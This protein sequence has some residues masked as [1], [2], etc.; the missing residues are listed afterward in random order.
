[1]PYIFQPKQFTYGPACN[2]GIELLAAKDVNE[3]VIVIG[4]DRDMRLGNNNDPGPTDAMVDDLGF[5]DHSH[6]DSSRERPQSFKDAVASKRFRSYTFEEHM[7]AVH[8]Q[9]CHLEIRPA[10]MP[11]RVSAAA[12]MLPEITDCFLWTVPF[13]FISAA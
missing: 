1:V 4:V 7:Q 6:I 2:A 3:Y 13:C 12:M 5:S 11:T 8:T 10:T 9:P